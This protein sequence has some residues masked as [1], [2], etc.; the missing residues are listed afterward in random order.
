MLAINN[1]HSRDQ[2]ISFQEIGHLY[3]IKGET[4]Y[5]SVTTIIKSLFEEFDA[6]KIIG[7]MMANKKILDPTNKYYGL[8]ATQIEDMW[9]ANAMDA[10]SK[11]TALHAYIENYYNGLFTKEESPEINQFKEFAKE[12]PH[13]LAYRTE[14]TVFYEEYKICGSIDMVFYNE[15]TKSYE[16][17]DWK[18]VGEIKYE[19]F[20]DKTAIVPCINHIPD[21]N[22]WHY[23]LQLNIYKCIL[24]KKYDKTIDAMYLVV[25]HPEKKKY[26]RIEIPTL[27]N[28]IALLLQWRLT[29]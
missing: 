27:T 7:K 10:S 13:L 4:D 24:E 22:F 17:Y 14:W 11:G 5:T 23:A 16:I 28:E 26:E 15:T 2:F 19:A 20:C 8:T 25:C 12:Y 21:T 18:R 1:S 3:T 29:T 6:K 9:S